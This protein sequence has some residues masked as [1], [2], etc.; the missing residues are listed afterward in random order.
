MTRVRIAPHRLLHYLPWA[1]LHD[2]HGWLVDRFEISLVP[3][4][5]LG[6]GGT[7]TPPPRFQKVLA[8]GFGGPDLPQVATEAVA[9]AAA[10]GPGATLLLDAAATGAALRREAPQADLL[11]LACHAHFRADSP[12]FSALHLADGELTLRDAAALPLGATLV[13]LSACETGLSRVAPGDDLVGL[14]RGFLLGGARHVMASLWTVDDA[15]TAELMKSVYAGLIDG[16]RPARAL[17][18][19][20]S[21]LAR[22]GHHPFYWAAFALHS[23]G[24]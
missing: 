5:R 22:A 11:H 8:L 2:G 3:S 14:V 6:L 23:R 13:T 7:D 18:A 20:Q 17:Q 9:V 21:A 1:A 10:F 24:R 12:Y 16:Q 4:A 19:A 15:S